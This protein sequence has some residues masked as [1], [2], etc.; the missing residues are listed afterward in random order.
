MAW[1]TLL[2]PAH[3]S[4]SSY[5]SSNQQDYFPFALPNGG[6][7][8]AVVK[9]DNSTFQLERQ[10]WACPMP[11]SVNPGDNPWNTM[12]PLSNTFSML[13]TNEGFGAAAWG[14]GGSCAGTF[15]QRKEA[16]SGG[17]PLTTVFPGTIDGSIHMGAGACLPNLTHLR[18]FT[19]TTCTPGAKESDFGYWGYQGNVYTP[20]WLTMAQCASGAAGG[21]ESPLSISYD[22]N[23]N[24]ISA[25]SCSY[26]TPNRVCT[27]CAGSRGGQFN[28]SNDD[29]AN[30]TQGSLFLEP[31]GTYISQQGKGPYNDTMYYHGHSAVSAWSDNHSD[32]NPFTNQNN[33][34]FYQVGRAM[35]E[36]IANDLSGSYYMSGAFQGYKEPGYTLVNN[37][38][39]W[40]QNIPVNVVNPGLTVINLQSSY[41]NLVSNLP[42]PIAP[43]ASYNRPWLGPSNAQAGVQESRGGGTDCM[44][45]YAIIIFPTTTA[46]KANAKFE[47]DPIDF[48]LHLDYLSVGWQK[49]FGNLYPFNA[50]GG[51]LGDGTNYSGIRGSNYMSNAPSWHVDR[52]YN[53][54]HPFAQA[55]TG[56]QHQL[57]EYYSD[58]YGTPANKLTDLKDNPEM[59]QMFGGILDGK[60]ED[61]SSKWWE[62][63]TNNYFNNPWGIEI[64]NEMQKHI[65]KETAYIG[66]PD[67]LT[68]TYADRDNTI[69]VVR[70]P[71]AAPHWRS[72][73]YQTTTA[74]NPIT[75][76]L[77]FNLHITGPDDSGNGKTVMFRDVV[78]GFQDA[79]VEVHGTSFNF[80]SSSN[81][82]YWGGADEWT[83][84]ANQSFAVGIPFHWHG[85][86]GYSSNTPFSG[87]GVGHNSD[88]VGS[89]TISGEP[90][91][92]WRNYW[93]PNY[94]EGRNDIHSTVV[95]P[96]QYTGFDF[97]IGDGSTPPDYGDYS[98]SETNSYTSNTGA[99]QGCWFE[100]DGRIAFDGSALIGSTNPHDAW[101]YQSGKSRPYNSIFLNSAGHANYTQSG[102]RYFFNTITN[103]TT[104]GSA[105]RN[106]IA[107][108]TTYNIN[109]ETYPGDYNGLPKTCVV[110]GLTDAVAHLRYIGVWTAYDNNVG[111]NYSYISKPVPTDQR[112][113]DVLRYVKNVNHNTG[114][115]V[116]GDE[117]ENS[118]YLMWRTGAG[119]MAIQT[120]AP[121]STH[122]NNWAMQTG[123]GMVYNSN[124]IAP[125]AMGLTI[126]TTDAT[127]GSANGEV[128]FTFSGPATPWLDFE[129]LHDN[130]SGAEVFVDYVSGSTWA[131]RVPQTPNANYDN[132]CTCSGTI[133]ST[134][135]PSYT[136]TGI[137][138][139]TDFDLVAQTAYAN[140]GCNFDTTFT[141][142]GGDLFSYTASAWANTPTSCNTSITHVINLTATNVS[143]GV[144]PNSGNIMGT[145]FKTLPNGDQEIVQHFVPWT[146]A[147]TVTNSNGTVIP[148]LGADA[149]C[150]SGNGCAGVVNTGDTA[151]MQLG[152]P[153]LH[154]LTPTT[155]TVIFHNEPADSIIG[156]LNV[157]S[158]LQDD[159]IIQKSITVMCTAPTMTLYPVKAQC[160]QSD[161]YNWGFSNSW[162]DQADANGMMPNGLTPLQTG[163]IEVMGMGS[164]TIGYYE[165]LDSSGTII[166]TYGPGSSGSELQGIAA[167][168][169]SLNYYLNITDYNNGTIDQTL[170]AT[171]GQV[172]AGIICTQPVGTN[173]VGCGGGIGGTLS[174]FDADNVSCGNSSW[175]NCASTG[176]YYTYTDNPNPFVWND[177][178]DRFDAF[179]LNGSTLITPTLS[180]YFTNVPPGTWY[181]IARSGCNC[182]VMSNAVTITG[183]TNLAY[184]LTASTPTCAGT[185]SVITATIATGIPPFSYEWSSTDPAFVPPAVYFTTSTASSVAASSG[186]VYT[187]AVNDQT[188]CPEQSSSIT[189]NASPGPVLT[190]SVQSNIGCGASSTSGSITLAPTGG[191]GSYTYL[192]S[193]NSSATTQNL[194]GI[195]VGTYTVVIT[196]ST[197]CT[198][199][200]TFTLVS[201]GA[202]EVFVD[203]NNYEYNKIF[204]STTIGTAA[205]DL[206]YGLYGGP[207]CPT[208]TNGNIKLM[209]DSST[210]TGTFP[211]D[212]YI[213]PAGSGSYQQ[214][215]DNSGTNLSI[216]TVQAYDTSTGNIVSTGLSY[217]TSNVAS[218]TYFQITGGAGGDKVAGAVLAFTAGSSWD[219]KVVE[220]GGTGQ[221]PSYHTAT[222]LASDY[223]N[224]VATTTHVDP[225]CC[226]CSSYGAA[227]VNVCN[228]SIDL[229]PTLGTYENQALD[230]AYSY[231]WTYAALPST[232][233]IVGHINA[234]TQWSN[235]TTQDLAAGQWPGSYTCTVTDSCGGTSAPVTTLEDPVV[236]IDDITW[237]HPTCIDCPDGSITIT[238]HGGNGNIEV[239]I[240]NGNT[241]IAVTGV[242]TFTGLNGGIKS[243]WVRDG[244][245]CSSEY[246]AD[247]DD[248]TVLASYDNNCHAD[249]EPCLISVSGTW[250]PTLNLATSGISAG[251][252]FTEGSCT[253]IELIPLS[254]FT[255]A[256]ACVTSHCKFPGD[257]AGAILLNLAGG[258]PPYTISAVA[259]SGPV[260]SASTGLNNCTG[261]GPLTQEPDKCTLTGTVM[262]SIGLNNNIWGISE[263]GGLTYSD[264]DAA[265][266]YTTSATSFM[267]QDVSVSL[268]LG[269]S[270]LGA[271]YR[272]Y[273]QDSA[274][275]V[276]MSTVGIDNGIFGLI[277]I[278]GA[279]NCD[280]IC[281]IGYTLDSVAG[282]ATNGECVSTEIA[283]I[284]AN[285][286]TPDY[287]TLLP[288]L[289]LGQ[290]TPS[291]FASNG[292][293]IYGPYDPVTGTVNYSASI[294]INVNALPL[295]RDLATAGNN[296]LVMNDASG[297]LIGADIAAI[298][299]VTSVW[300]TRLNQIAIWRNSG[301]V[302]IFPVS[303]QN[304]FIGVITEINF[305]TTQES[306]IAISGSEEVKMYIDGV[307][308][309]HLDAT[310]NNATTIADN[311]DYVN[312]F[313]VVLPS[314]LHS[315][316]FQAMNTNS[317]DAFLAFEIYPNKL[318]FG[319]LA[320]AYFI[321]AILNPAF[322]IADLTSNILQDAALNNLSSSSYDNIEIQIGETIGYSCPTVGTTVQLSG[323]S[324]FC[325]SDV[326]APCEVPLD[327][328]ACYDVDG[329]PVP[330][331]TK[332]GP[333]VSATDN[334]GFLVDNVWVTDAS[335][336]ANLVECPGT[337]AN[338]ALAKIQGALASNV[339]D[340]RQVWLTI[341]IKHMLQNLNICFSLADIQ[342]SFTGYLDEVCPTCSVGDQLTPAQMEAVVSQIFNTNNS[343]Y[344]F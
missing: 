211:Y 10:S 331:L 59:A 201:I 188:G 6:L 281:P 142:P 56:V 40:G 247:P 93:R 334:V 165:W 268:D 97:W 263:D 341:M 212:V 322:T 51:H 302:G 325:V 29:Y 158:I 26:C 199:T 44:S 5:K 170:T 36:I 22:H 222:I 238:T 124:Y 137:P 300:N 305:L 33:R 269:G 163:R 148:T 242:Y 207:L 122:L 297:P 213:K 277:S 154:T 49:V 299:S 16:A 168:S 71:A 178:L 47:Y 306:I 298:N 155:Y 147:N 335:A 61:L 241:Y 81:A 202:A 135:L 308:Y 72:L 227:G 146:T 169:Y 181:Q 1:Y 73:S 43:D 248:Q 250:I 9:L 235:L 159:C 262:P 249:F 314:G 149:G 266:H 77:Y 4:G 326:T 270:F 128:T 3:S 21:F 50:T 284:I 255:D 342:D 164:D 183:G 320:G 92:N 240:D 196:D 2:P 63:D 264:F 219:I 237:T 307:E 205:D 121:T 45:Y 261:I 14:S 257:T 118:E 191:S 343:N 74:I 75:D 173:V 245:G 174:G 278:Y 111:V 234:N 259:T 134:S 176:P 120:S 267:I 226:G 133:P 115:V 193:G 57:T 279:V 39:D 236:Y 288:N 233:S 336:L 285:T 310:T 301:T 272:F 65:L 316:S 220:N 200:E 256:S 287:W 162:S 125:C 107:A 280:C 337:L 114:N 141:V 265:T 293:I 333:C 303:P 221:C 251:A 106:P 329:F 217:D 79:A 66:Y 166:F 276:Q 198:A 203:I 187:C 70:T 117:N 112:Y 186:F 204:D 332:K 104:L 30:T 11:D 312:L 80:I 89:S 52:Y 101:D 126:T 180:S 53:A 150:V 295:V 323:S 85:G 309:I 98:A 27:S 327:C 271:Q 344:D 95:L 171:T 318:G 69:L 116:W 60:F 206:L 105:N 292:A 210:S 157:S 46:Q 296:L 260:Y 37:A 229:T 91:G 338:E 129:L 84:P 138:A 232:C 156:D 102:G 253:K 99:Q 246:F 35:E 252:A 28:Y 13:N 209:L 143:G 86:G 103:N 313:P 48:K 82:G 311:T 18:E 130:N 54:E 31:G 34:S 177:T 274:G 19:A 145:V 131:Y 123:N 15:G 76:N 275:C 58:T 139:N 83:F 32:Y 321:S 55:N 132:F 231:L 94:A 144:S 286:T 152:I 153:I 42:Y 20:G 41:T 340:I 88:I 330:D 228:G 23:G 282:S 78:T 17:C 230:T 68:P 243:I 109:D 100:F 96:I 184:N 224:V 113:I 190:N 254:T 38:T 151:V 179:N 339:L 225:N 87:C 25:F 289:Y 7:K 328:G 161:P 110:N 239:S 62:V 64:L 216:T 319:A 214:V 324:M 167:G 195:T 8:F 172:A 194:T 291:N 108:V 317:N 215:T 294:N 218:N 258:T 197:G 119:F 315:I 140:G 182:V 67:E 244:S 283:S 185:T 273:V 192:W 160:S 189:A 304:E 24:I 127:C 136:L 175:V 223:Q 208:S 12:Y 290:S 90:I